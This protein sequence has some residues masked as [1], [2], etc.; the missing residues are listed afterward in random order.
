MPNFKD[1]DPALAGPRSFFK[2][3]IMLILLAATAISLLCW[4]AGGLVVSLTAETGKSLAFSTF[5]GDRWNI[6]FTHSVEKTPWE[7]FFL[8]NGANDMTL[9]HTRFQ[10]F[11]WGY[12]YSAADGRISQTG[13]GRFMLEMH[14]PYKSVKLRV[15]KQAMQHVIHG[16][17]DYSLVDIFGHGMAIDIKA[18][19]RF[20]YWLEKYE[21]YFD[22]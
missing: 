20:E 11:G 7:E 6:R 1:R 22:F 9:T 16:K 3:P 10:S 5:P 21:K 19:Y 17:D 4:Y 8:V 2:K 14:R 12:P 13:D 18:Q 15:A